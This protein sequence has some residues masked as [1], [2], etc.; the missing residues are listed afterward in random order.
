MKLK[1]FKFKSV[2]STND[3]AIKIIKTS[4]IKSGMIIAETQKNGRGQYGKKWISYKGNL[5]TTIFFSLDKINLTIKQLTIINCFLVKKLLS[6][7]YKKKIIVKYPNDLII[8]KQKISGILQET[9][10]K[11]NS[12]YMIVGIGINLVKNP[13]IKNYKTT[14]LLS[15]TKR[16]I[17]KKK[18]ISD[19]KNIY[20]NFIKLFYKSKIKNI[21]KV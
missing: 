9:L 14:N 1:K 12:N 17:Y 13:N 15:V 19:L 20:E 4:K 10:V 11:D 3:I 18:I 5:F 8:N 16:I 2:N 21:M 7:Y 6:Y